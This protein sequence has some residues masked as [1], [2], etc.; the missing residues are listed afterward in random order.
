MADDEIAEVRQI[1]S[2]LGLPGVID[3]HTHFMPKSVMD[4][5]WQCSPLVRTRL[6][7][8]ALPSQSTTSTK[9]S[10]LPR[11]TGAARFAA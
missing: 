1:W 7:C 6:A 9:P 10:R 11:G 5:V 2:A 8:T 4:K 3:V